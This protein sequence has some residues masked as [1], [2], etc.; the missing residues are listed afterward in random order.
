MTLL[1][2]ELVAHGIEGV[3]VEVVVLVVLK[4]ETITN[5]NQQ[6]TTYTKTTRLPSTMTYIS[7]DGT[8]G[9]TKTFWKSITDFLGAIWSLIGLF[10]ATMT[11]AKAIDQ[12]RR[13]TSSRTFA[14]RNQGRSYR[15]SGQSLG[16][17]N[18]APRKGSNIRGVSNLGDANCQVGGG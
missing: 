1:L 4:R 3:V 8:V 15:G 11:N 12:N 10:F 7:A 5:N 17:G 2:R 14:Q 9:G 6:Q 16:G 13:S 18:I